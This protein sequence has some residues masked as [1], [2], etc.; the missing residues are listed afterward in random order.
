MIV[1]KFGGSSVK[2]AEN[3]LKV[4]DIIKKQFHKKTP[5]TVVVSAFGGVTDSLIKMSKL[6]SKGDHGYKAVLQE[7]KTRHL[8]TAKSLV[9]T[10]VYKQL[11]KDLVINHT[12]LEDLLKGIFLV[13]E[14]SPRTMDYVL[15]FGE[16]N[17]AFII[18]HAL[19]EHAIKSA[20]LDA[21]LIIA[22]DKKFGKANVDFKETQKRITKHYKDNAKEVQIVTGFISADKGGLTTTLGRG[23]S[24]YTASLLASC[25]K[26]KQLEIWTDVDGVLTTDPRKVSKAFTVPSLSYREAMEL[27]HFGAKVIYP[28]TLL[29]ALKRKI[30]ILIRNT[31][32]P[33]FPGTII[34]HKTK[35]SLEKEITGLS[36]LNGI[37]LMRLQGGGMVGMPG[38]AARLFSALASQEINIILI[39]QGSSEYAISF[40]VDSADAKQA[41]VVIEEAFDREIEAGLI[42]EVLIEDKQS[43]IAIVSE[44]MRNQPGVAGKLFASLGKEGINVNAI[45]QGSSECNIS[46]VVSEEEEKKA[47]NLIHDSFF[48]SGTIDINLYMIGVGL[49]GGTLISQLKQQAKRLK[50]EQNLAIKF[51]GLSNSRK[52]LINQDGIGMDDWEDSLDDSYLKAN[53]DTFVEQMIADNLPN[54]IFIDSTANATIPDFYQEVLENNISIVTPNKI[55]TSSSYKNYKKLKDTAKKHHTAFLYETNV[56]AGL[57]VITTL[58]NL[59]S[60]GDQITKL[61]AV[62]SGSISYIFNT[63]GNGKSFSEV[64]MDAKNLGLTEP[65]PRDDLSGLDVK[66]KITI[67]AR[68]AGHQV[69][70]SG[71]KLKGILNK[72]CMD[73]KSVSAFFKEL[74]KLNH[75]FEKM[76]NDAAKKKKKLR[77]IATMEKTGKCSIGLQEVGEKSPFY[78]LGGSDNMLVIT[79]KRYDKRPLVVKGPGAGAEVT[80]AGVFA[81]II[82]IANSVA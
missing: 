49:I 31:F 18:S 46:F 32:N 23:G 51:I 24:D 7:F 2:N 55:A 26:A 48:L 30:P 59:V 16:R 29:P 47:L 1:L 70:M 71:V 58:E 11:E 64:V 9:S 21:R 3:I 44:Q 56:G 68:E 17:S 62:L 35:P 20:Y 13:R 61:E 25:L 81:E 78:N 43:I 60:S 39:T 52:M 57:P 38:I 28:P 63:F 50:K 79:T 54:S 8:M 77:F 76:S 10:Q 41:K 66:R 82:S 19:R 80:A 72:A 45:A 33:K 27:S 75:G 36:S 42:S 34:D 4:K 65:D 22:T 37:S 15:S 69:N 73:A 67:L 74:E 40:A 12:T 6:A 53:P 5:Y 14:V